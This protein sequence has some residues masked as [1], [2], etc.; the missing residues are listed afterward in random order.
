MVVVRV[1]GGKQWLATYE[2]RQAVLRAF[3]ADDSLPVEM[4]VGPLVVGLLWAPCPVA[5]SRVA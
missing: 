3:G 5:L 4:L 2:R 1:E